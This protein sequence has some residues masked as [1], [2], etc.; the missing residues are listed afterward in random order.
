MIRHNIIIQ[1]V[2]GL[3]KATGGVRATFT[4]GGVGLMFKW[5]L[6]LFVLNM[7]E[8]A[9]RGRIM[10]KERDIPCWS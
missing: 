6:Y 1:F 2:H 4:I 7:K 3:V 10:K 8:F 9:E 5:V